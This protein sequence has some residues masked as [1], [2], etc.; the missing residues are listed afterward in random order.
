MRILNNLLKTFGI[1]GLLYS[2][3]AMFYFNFNIGVICTL[4]ISLLAII[5]GF[6]LIDFMYNKIILIPIIIVGT[7]FIFM[8][9]FLFSYSHNNNVTY[10][11]DALIVLGAG[12]IDG[13][14][15]S[16]SLK[17]RLD[18]AISYYNKNNN[19]IIVVSGGQGSDEKIS[20]ALAMKNY[21]LEHDIPSDSIIMED[22][23]TST[24][25]NFTFSK[26]ILD[27]ILKP[28][29][30]VAFVTSDFHVFR[31]NKYAK[32]VGLNPTHYYA[33]TPITTIPINYTREAIAVVVSFIKK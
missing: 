14:K 19:A 1:I 16:V 21:L 9:V 2:I 23:S 30:K 29:Y 7:I 18:S 10:D 4:G 31:A 8:C 22:K 6:H 11:E 17:L 5:Y 25:E 3:F 33:K 27:N 15:V 13:D 28:D 26:N 12:L 20:E 24:L 32:K